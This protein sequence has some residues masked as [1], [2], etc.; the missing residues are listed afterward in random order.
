MDGQEIDAALRHAGDRARDGLR[1]V[2]ELQVE[3][4]P[5][6]RRKQLA[7]EVHSAG[8]EELQADFVE[9]HPGTDA[10]H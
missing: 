4:D 5:L 7:H 8:G 10:L 3:E 2:V 6:A 1:D 9:R